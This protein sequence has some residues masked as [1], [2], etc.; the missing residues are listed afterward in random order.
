MTI[1]KTFLSVCALLCFFKC[2]SCADEN[3]VRQ[4]SAVNDQFQ[5]ESVDVSPI[6]ACIANCRKRH[7]LVP[8]RDFCYRKVCRTITAAYEEASGHQH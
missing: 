3:E 7:L 1:I 4:V 8:S 5:R 2:N 6:L